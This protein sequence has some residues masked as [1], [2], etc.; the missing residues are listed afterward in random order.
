M[1]K[2]LQMLKAVIFDWVGTLYER[3]EAP[4]PWSKE[5]LLKLKQKYKL[6]LVTLAAQ[7]KKQRE[8][9]IENSGLK[10]LFD[11]VVI[12]ET[13]NEEEYI[14]CMKDLGTKPEETAVVDD[15]MGRLKVAA[16]LG[17]QVYWVNHRGEETG[18][19]TR[20]ETV[21]DLVTLI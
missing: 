8:S 7:G 9:E 11:A 2:R 16:T 1:E 4:Y 15:Q 5:T 6:G 14:K 20:I 10:H 18:E 19:V 13:K 3:L 21:Q 12:E 17:C